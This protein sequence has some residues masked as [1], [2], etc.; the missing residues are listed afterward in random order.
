METITERFQ[1]YLKNHEKY[2]NN[3]LSIESIQEGISKLESSILKKQK[4]YNNEKTIKNKLEDEKEKLQK[5]FQ[6]QKYFYSKCR[7]DSIEDNPDYSLEMSNIKNEYTDVELFSKGQYAIRKKYD[8]I[9][10]EY[11]VKR[12]EELNREKEAICQEEKRF[13]QD[14]TAYLHEV[15]NQKHSG[16]VD[17]LE[18]KKKEV[19]RYLN[20]NS[21]IK[22]AESAKKMREII[23]KETIFRENCGNSEKKLINEMISLKGTE[24]YAVRKE[25]IDIYKFKRYRIKNKY[26]DIRNLLTR[27]DKHSEYQ[28]VFF[29]PFLIICTILLFIIFMLGFSPLFF[30]IPSSNVIAG[31][32]GVIGRFVVKFFPSLFMAAITFFVAYFIFKLCNAEK[33]GIILGGIIGIYI[34]LSLFLAYSPNITAQTMKGFATVV[35]YIIA[36]II[37][38]PIVV[39]IIYIL[40]YIILNT[41]IVNLF[42]HMQEDK[43]LS[44]LREFEEYFFDN[45]ETFIA[46]FHYM[47]AISF[48]CENRFNLLL[49]NIDKDI[50]R[51]QEEKGFL[52]LETDCEKELKRRGQER[53]R[54]LNELKK[55]RDNLKE[56]VNRKNETLQTMNNKLCAIDNDIFQMSKKLNKEK[57]IEKDL[58]HQIASDKE[59]L[60]QETEN[61]ISKDDREFDLKCNEQNTA[62]ELLRCKGQL[63]KQIYF[64][65]K[66][67]DKYQM[68]EVIELDLKCEHTVFVYDQNDISGNNL[69]EELEP[70]IKW[71]VEAIRRTNPAALLYRWFTIVD[72]MSGKSVLTMPP[73]DRF[74]DVIDDERGKMRLCETLQQK[75]I[76][77]SSAMNQPDIRESGKQIDSVDDLNAIKMEINEPDIMQQPNMPINDLWEKPVPYNIIIFIVPNIIGSGSQPS[78][79]NDELKRILMNVKHYGII[80]VF[81]VSSST[82]DD[83]KNSSDVVYLHNVQN[84]SIIRISHVGKN[85]EESIDILDK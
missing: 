21:K 71:F 57:E 64:V 17:I 61:I 79:L 40:H 34:F 82:W 73:Y 85:N 33:V 51:V 52:K 50:D 49:S 83:I 38:L 80:P 30:L 25:K 63:S 68:A 27:Y 60:L 35:H 1:N 55:K 43:V 46:L 5:E 31:I 20:A 19:I 42:F 67:K 41:S 10:Q 65:R 13:V 7:G 24:N 48:A 44:D 29:Y 12:K 39:L 37:N 28:S 70:F 77:V 72:M 36:V 11:Y 58:L 26:R 56:E 4:T 76:S 6:K 81:L 62:L 75:E 74:L 3:I 32:S 14:K 16:C 15:M 59:K 23:E 8:I 53:E 84:K 47:E 69:S 45:K 22:Y 54:Q 66:K 2:K 9:K 18:K 78:V